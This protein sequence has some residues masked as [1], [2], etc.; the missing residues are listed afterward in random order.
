MGVAPF[1]FLL[2]DCPFI[3]ALFAIARKLPSANI[4]FV[5]L[6]IHEI[7]HQLQDSVLESSFVCEINVFVNSVC[8]STG[9]YC[10]FPSR[11]L[12]SDFG[13]LEDVLSSEI[14]LRAL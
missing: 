10:E 8:N 11:I 4:V 1:P 9:T 12:C 3:S 7:P 6:F 14:C 5:V 2:E 13:T